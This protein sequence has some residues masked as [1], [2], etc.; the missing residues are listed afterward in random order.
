[1]EGIFGAFLIVS[2]IHMGEEYFYPGGFM[3]VMKH[4]N[5]KFAPL[6]TAPMAV[7]INGLQLLLC[8]IAIV[9]GKNVLTFSMSVPGLLFINGLMHI[10]GCFRVKGYAPG[11]I[12]GVLLYMPLSVYAYYF[13]IS[14]GQ[15]TLNGVIVTGVLG[16]LYQAVPIS[17]FV[18]ASSIRRP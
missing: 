7:I 1:M 17:Y 11:V 9:V 6:V 16:L 5:P 3:D 13:F 8:I 4:L 2:M 12:T 15:L 10:M 14:S 18:L